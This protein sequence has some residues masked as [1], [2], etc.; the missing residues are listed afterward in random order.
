MSLSSTGSGSRPRSRTAAGL[1]PVTADGIIDAA[2][3]L[4]VEHGLENWT[5]RQ[6]A[7]AVDAYPAV[8]Y[9]HVGDRDAVVKEV[10]ERVLMR[11]PVP[12]ADLPWRRWFGDVLVGM[13]PVL[14]EYPGSARRI[15]LFELSVS[16]SAI[17]IERGVGT[18]LRAGFG[19]ESVLVHTVLM[20]TA[21]QHIAM[22]DDRDHQVR[23]RFDNAE[24]FLAYRDRQ[25]KP[26][27][28]AMAEALGETMEKP[29]M[30]AGYFGLVY[31]YA[32]ARCLVGVEARLREVRRLTE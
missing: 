26:G 15:M 1:P 17:L 5:V 9:H 2:M 31:E 14:R 20:S 8:I 22:E 21:F 13:R 24:T 30:A 12:D 28:A 4:T 25:D 10:C 18:L 11:L 32:V 19:E 29:E 16:S 27:L 3:R 6:L 23:A 7:A